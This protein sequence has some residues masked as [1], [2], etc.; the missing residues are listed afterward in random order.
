MKGGID[1]VKPIE[2]RTEHGRHAEM[3]IVTP[4]GTVYSEA[5]RWSPCRRG[6]PDGDFCHNNVPLISQMVPGE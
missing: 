3:E 2:D 6:G 4:T 1:E 5:W